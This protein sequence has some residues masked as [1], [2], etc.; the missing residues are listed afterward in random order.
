MN[1]RKLS[2]RKR[3][4]ALL[5][6]LGLLGFLMISAVAF[7]ISMRTERA[8]AASFRTDVRTR[9]LLA[10]AFADARAS[11]EGAM[12]EQ[13]GGSDPADNADAR[14]VDRI[15]PFRVSDNAYARLISS[16]TVGSTDDGGDGNAVAYL[17]DDAV[18][19]HVPPYIASAVYNALEPESGTAVSGSSGRSYDFD[20]PA[21]WRPVYASVPETDVEV[22]GQTFQRSQALV[23]RMA[24][25]V[26]NLSD[27]IDINGIG[28][29]SPYR[30]LGLS[31]SE[32]AFGK[33]PSAD[34][35]VRTYDLVEASADES[36]RLEPELPV[37]LSNADL[38]TYAAMTNEGNL[39]AQ[40]TDNILSYAWQDAALYTGDGS[41]YYAPFSVYSFWPTDRK[42]EEGNLI[43][44][45]GA[46]AD[47]PSCDEITA[48]DLTPGSELANRIERAL[49]A[50]GVSDGSG[51]RDNFIRLL[52]DYIDTDCEPNAL[53]LRSG[54]DEY[55]N[56]APTVENVPMIME[57]GYDAAEVDEA[58]ATVL[59]TAVGEMEG[60]EKSGL[61]VDAAN[62]LKTYPETL[63][64][65]LSGGDIALPLSLR[66]YFPGYETASDSAKGADVRAEGHVLFTLVSAAASDVSSKT[67]TADAEASF[68]A[69]QEAVWT[70][71]PESAD[72][73]VGSLSALTV[74]E[75]T[76]PVKIEGEG[77][78]AYDPGE[79]TLSVLADYFFRVRI[80]GE[81]PYDMA[82]AGL[83]QAPDEIAVSDLDARLNETQMRTY[84]ASFFR[85]TRL[86]Q[87]KVKPYW[88]MEKTGGEAEGSEP[89]YTATLKFDGTPQI[90]EAAQGSSLTVGPRDFAYPDGGT[91]SLYTFAPAQGVWKTVDPRYNWLS[92]MLGCTGSLENYGTEATNAM[93]GYSSPHWFFLPESADSGSSLMMA[94]GYAER[95]ADAV[96][97]MFGLKWEDVRY[98]TNDTGRLYLPGEIGFLP[99]PFKD[100]DWTPTGGYNARSLDTYYN[101]VARCSYF[102]TLPVTEFG[103]ASSAFGGNA[104]WSE[105][106]AVKLTQIFRR[107]AAPGFPEEHRAILSVFAAQDNY[108]LAQR[109]RQFAMCGIMPSIREAVAVSRARLETAQEIGRVKIEDFD[110]V[111]PRL[112]GVTLGEPKY[113]TFICKYLFP[114]PGE[115]AA[116]SGISSGSGN[117]EDWPAGTRPQ[118]L[119]FLSDMDTA[120]SGTL[121][122]AKRLEAYNA[123]EGAGEPL[124]Q[125]DLTTLLSVAGE[126]FGDRQQ[127]FL[128]I[129]RADSVASRA[130]FSLGS[131]RPLASARAVALVW[132]DAYGL[133]PD[134]VV[135]Y[136]VLP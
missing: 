123:A 83:D 33:A 2:E 62:N 70:E 105:E 14:T 91:A 114:L 68:G 93:P 76:I 36:G 57:V 86:V 52:T 4:S 112:E 66:T 82:P 127:L 97:F 13:L 25:A 9:D 87:I 24:W 10:M 71:T 23:G 100:A 45:S 8:A 131:Y 44:S 21:C 48:E 19:A 27:S 106:N 35:S 3:G 5:I 41:G 128:Y 95:H 122:V 39:K 78:T 22:D 32:F 26:V 63:E 74:D 34:P 55:A 108:A 116:G 110:E 81:G 101:T 117:P 79:V 94:D 28:S 54:G 133:L 118:D 120:S 135:Y 102:R 60:Y 77:L 18:M 113:D 90:V 75:N 51:I 16:R 107:F 42:D 72:L 69:P 132:R 50:A 88:Q 96:P 89:T 125:N 80:D 56:A 17:L 126:C 58:I 64:I 12:T 115:E 85:V 49:T 37:F 47:T 31:G 84:D 40:G 59:E 98:G 30:G 73:T 38:Y 65:E 111:F 136:Q 99:V 61:S 29:F 67:A 129:L 46:D 43:A 103:E 11:L 124:G 20:A 121:S 7:S 6:V 104:V 130:G 92:P 119:N 15:A 1:F 134:R 53:D 109:L